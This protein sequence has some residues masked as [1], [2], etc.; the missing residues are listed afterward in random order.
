[1]APSST[2]STA[3]PRSAAVPT[4]TKIASGELGL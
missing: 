4:D 3:L 1:M 2:F